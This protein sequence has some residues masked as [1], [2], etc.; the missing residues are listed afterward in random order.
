M[1]VIWRRLLLR[2][3]RPRMGG[4]GFESHYI[5]LF[6]SINMGL[7]PVYKFIAYPLNIIITLKHS[8]T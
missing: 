1:K 5:F 3:R 7:N 6:H 8:E 4:R 2:E